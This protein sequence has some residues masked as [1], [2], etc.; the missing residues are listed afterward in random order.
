MRSATGMWLATYILIP[1][2]IFL[3]IKA[4]NESLGIRAYISRLLKIFKRISKLNN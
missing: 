3:T 4:A 1:I 2:A